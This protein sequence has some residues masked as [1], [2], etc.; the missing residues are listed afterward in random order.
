MGRWFPPTRARSPFGLHLFAGANSAMLNFL[1][2]S[3]PENAPALRRTAEKAG[4]NLRAAIGLTATAVL[5]QQVLRLTVD[6]HNRAGH[7]LPTGFPSRRV[8][9]HIQ[10][11]GS[12]RR[13]LFESGA[14]DAGGLLRASAG[15]PHRSVITLPEQTMI[16][17]AV[18]ADTVGRPTTSLLRAASYWKDNRILP[19]GF[20]L[21]RDARLAP[22]G[23]ANDSGFRPGS[24]RVR[25]EIRIPAGL[26]PGEV[27][28]EAVYQAID[29]AWFPSGSP[30][31]IRPT[32][33]PVVMAETSVS[34]KTVN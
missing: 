12:D 1:A 27:K 25:Y 32:F 6:L 10:V 14:W 20:D 8:W 7:K 5:E 9:L 2:G 16:Y 29:P 34:L 31:A 23:V 13:M 4:E 28:V 15:E 30:G 22:A 18:P 26:R 17:Q 3:E 11:A 24:H 21:A 33:L 19:A